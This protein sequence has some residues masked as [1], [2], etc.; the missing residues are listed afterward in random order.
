MKRR[1]T[2]LFILLLLMAFITTSVGA[3]DYS[4]SVP[5]MDV[6]VFLNE[7][8][9]IGVEYLIV[10]QNDSGGHVIDFVD[11]GMPNGGYELEQHHCRRKR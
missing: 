8:G 3:Q 10:F 6:H 2:V 1:L 5:K 7:D 9:T 11:I 4:F